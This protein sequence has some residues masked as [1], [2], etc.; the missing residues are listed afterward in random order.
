MNAGVVIIGRNEGDRLPRCLRSVCAQTDCIVYA[1][2]GSTDGSPEAARRAG[3]DVVELDPSWP[4]SAARGRNEGFERVMQ[5]AP[6]VRYV[7][8]I[9]GDCE[10]F[11][12]WLARAVATLEA[13]PDVAV[14]A[15]R[16]REM[17]RNASIYNRLCDLEW[18]AVPG[19]VG[20]VGGIAMVRAETLQGAGGFDPSLIAGE[21]PELCYRL[22][23]AGWKI[24]RIPDDMAAHDAAMTRF[25]QWWRRSVR[26]GHAYAEGAWQHGR[27]P[28]RY[29]VRESASIAFW[30]GALPLGIAAASALAHPAALLL[31]AA[32]PALGWR[33]Y[34]G[35]RRRGMGPGD[36]ALYAAF[37]VLSK[38]PQA[39]GLCGFHGRRLAG[40]RRGLIE[41]KKPGRADSRGKKREPE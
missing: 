13:R 24:L 36:S 22:R 20:E 9:D 8:F 33:V 12:D 3:V 19:E 32:Y 10:L 30:G 39:V 4:F 28:G 26:S 14:V 15:G 6:R 38:F 2:S 11:P 18:A 25:A 27:E 37:C 16:L 31:A 23:R 17:N 29:R 5:R 34:R 35:V 41:Y 40:R 7:Q 21:E 1:D